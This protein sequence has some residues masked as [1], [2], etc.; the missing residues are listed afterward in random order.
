MATLKE[1]KKS[2]LNSI[3]ADIRIKYSPFTTILL[4]IICQDNVYN[5]GMGDN[6]VFSTFF[7]DR[8]L[9]V[10]NVIIAEDFFYRISLTNIHIMLKYYTFYKRFVV[11]STNY[12]R[13]H[14]IL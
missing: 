13:S 12:N 11:V 7:Y 8:N 4:L 6:F 14:H 3:I 1:K 9:N 2:N 5:G 10:I